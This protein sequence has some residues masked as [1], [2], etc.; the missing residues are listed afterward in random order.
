MR[1]SHL[2]GDVDDEL[3][4]VVQVGLVR[5]EFG[6]V[7]E[8]GLQVGDGLATCTAQSATLQRPHVNPEPIPVRSTLRLVTSTLRSQVLLWLQEQSTAT[9]QD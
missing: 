3:C 6:R 9:Q 1:A 2:G 7:G 8:D 4:A 5:G